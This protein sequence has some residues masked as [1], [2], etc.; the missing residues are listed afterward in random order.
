VEA[1]CA[2]F[3]E[4]KTP[5][6]EC[7]RILIRDVAVIAR[8]QTEL[9]ELRRCQPNTSLWKLRADALVVLLE[10]ARKDYEDSKAILADD[11]YAAVGQ[12]SRTKLR[13]RAEV[14]V[15]ALASS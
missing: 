7:A 5:R 4:E 15:K 11:Q 2:D 1:Y 14:V 10:V 6:A 13:E 3:L 12:G 8:M 9:E